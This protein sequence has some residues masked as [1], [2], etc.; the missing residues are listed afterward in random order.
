LRE[1]FG[2]FIAGLL[3]MGGGEP[4]GK[5][6]RWETSGRLGRLFGVI[7]RISRIET[8]KRGQAARDPLLRERGD[9]TGGK[10]TRGGLR[11]NG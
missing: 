10:R 1:S 2:T 8:L 3:V 6:K 9:G 4:G 5:R 7:P 11:P